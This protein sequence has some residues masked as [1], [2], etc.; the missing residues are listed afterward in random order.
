MKRNWNLWIIL[1]ICAIILSSCAGLT[2][3]PEAVLWGT[4]RAEGDSFNTGPLS[5]TLTFYEDGR[6]MLDGDETDPAEYV[7][8][9]PGRMKVTVDGEISVVNYEYSDDHLTFIFPESELSYQRIG[10]PQSTP[11]F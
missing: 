5:K 2:T 10:A 1:C 7:V 9:S 11:Q 8:I 6:L 3:K 4:W